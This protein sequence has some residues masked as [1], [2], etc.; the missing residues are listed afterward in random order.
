MLQIYGARD[1]VEAEYVRGLLTSEG[2][3]AVVLGTALEGARGDIPFAPAALPS[4][5]VNEVDLAAARVIIDEFRKGG[6]ANV[7]PQPQWTCPNCGET[8]EGQFTTC[9]KCGY[10]RPLASDKSDCEG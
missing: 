1:S 4:V 10:N 2:I 3:A 9:W 7:H 8:L 5:W 6:P